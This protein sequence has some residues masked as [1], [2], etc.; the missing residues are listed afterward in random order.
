MI[1]Q[2]PQQCLQWFPFSL[3]SQDFGFLLLPNQTSKA[4]RQAQTNLLAI[5]YKQTQLELAFNVTQSYICKYKWR[6]RNRRIQWMDRRAEEAS[7]ES[8]SQK[9]GKDGTE[10]SG[11][12]KTVSKWKYELAQLRLTLVVAKS[13]ESPPISSVFQF[14]PL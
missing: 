3:T 8:D 4:T 6:E 1:F 10:W 2:K 14:S 11:K 7:M 9:R 5:T 12:E 13:W